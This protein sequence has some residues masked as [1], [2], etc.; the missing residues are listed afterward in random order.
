MAVAGAG[1]FASALLSSGGSPGGK[2]ASPIDGNSCTQ[3][4]AGTATPQADWISTDIPQTGYVPGQTYNITLTGTHQGSSKIGF[5]C[6]AETATS[7]AGTWTITDTQRTK[8]ANSNGSVT[9]TSGGTSGQNTNTWSFQWT[10]PESGSG[11]VTF[12]AAVNATNSNS[13]TSG[14]VV[15]TTSVSHPENATTALRQL[16]SSFS[17]FPNPAEDQVSI[18]W[19]DAPGQ[20]SL[21]LFNTSGQIVLDQ[22]AAGGLQTLDLGGLPAGVYF[23]KVGTESLSAVERLVVR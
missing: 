19:E 13:G 6:T 9:H 18:R 3:C 4:H 5:E 14:D 22:Q 20:W 16:R 12:Y 11:E 15:Y 1:L 10:A 2:T 21:R 8:L 17:L 7:K 23:L